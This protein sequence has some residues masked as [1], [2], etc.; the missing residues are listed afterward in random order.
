MTKTV[1]V[2]LFC[3]LLIAGCRGQDINQPSESS[4][5]A[6]TDDDP[7]MLYVNGQ[8]VEIESPYREIAEG[9]KN[10][11]FPIV[12]TFKLMGYETEVKDNVV[13]IIKE[14]EYHLLL[15]L[16]KYKLTKADDPRINYLD[17]MA[18]DTYED[19]MC[20]FQRSGDELWVSIHYT[21]EAFSCLGMHFRSNIVGKHLI[22][23]VSPK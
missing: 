12:A 9:K 2:I 19:Y 11:M 3:I 20:Q 4:S 7:Y 1:I 13:E 15:D 14:D 6:Y 8:Y 16:E 23:I 17:V 18:G 21:S 10:I 22:A 5:E